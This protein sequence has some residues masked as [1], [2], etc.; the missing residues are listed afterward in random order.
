ML[1][2]V[3]NYFRTVYPMGVSTISASGGKSN[4]EAL[5]RFIEERIAPPLIKFSQ[6]KYVQVMQRTGLGIMS[7]LVV[8]SVFLLVASFPFDPWLNFLGDFRWVIAAA[9]GV[10]T[11]FIA[12]YT[13]I[14][15]SYGLVEFY[16]K[17][18]GENHDIIQPMI[19]SVASFLLLNPAQ[20]VTTLIEGIAEP[21]KFTGVP[22]AY[23]GAV[24]VFAA[25]IIAI[26][27]V[28]VYR[29]VINRKLVIKMPEG[30]PPMVS[31]SFIALIP[32]FVVIIM[33]WFVG[34]VF[35]INL[36]QTIAGIF[37]PLV[38]VG[39]SPVVVLISTFLNRILWAVG[40]HGSNIVNSVGGT[41]W[42]QMTQENLQALQA[43]QE[44]PY[45]FTSVWIDNYIWTGL[46]PLAVALIRSKSP[47]LKG[48]GK[49]S[50]AAAL[51]NIGEPLIFGLPI[52]LNPLM[53]IPFILSYMVLAIVAIIL[54][55]TG[56]LPV[57]VMIISW[58]TPAPLKTWLATSGSITA[59]LFVLAGWVF[60]YLTFYPFVKALEKQDLKEI[61]AAE[62]EA[63]K[64]EAA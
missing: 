48:L 1:K 4:M 64:T 15:A 30:V 54:T 19:L 7:L 56:V 18:R 42:G 62:E 28:E 17:Q 10:G 27:T 44:L 33:W 49:L 35:K 34:S 40:I 12:L 13:V 39:D 38:R 41:F 23:L 53:M 50:I 25:L 46:F 61:A 43:M 51:F 32:S 5:T 52:M 47:R 9:S 24:G 3:E 20:T 22:T 57:P 11:S 29:F 8:G 14:T 59:V 6:L 63:H 21:G 26:V 37:T 2:S 16:N 45:T 31:Q 58:I 36:P 55:L 60:M